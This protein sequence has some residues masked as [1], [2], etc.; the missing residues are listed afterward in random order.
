MITAKYLEKEIPH[1]N[2]DG[3]QRLYDLGH[4]FKLSLI[5]STMAHRY[6]FAWEAAV[7]YNGSLTYATPLTSNVEVFD[8]DDAA[9]AFIESAKA[10][11]DAQS[12]ESIAAMMDREANT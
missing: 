3:V 8:S 6:V 7:L 9:N 2:W 5:N 12:D 10:W 11:V 4:G 1:R